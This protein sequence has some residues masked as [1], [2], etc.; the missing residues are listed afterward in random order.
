MSDI[1]DVWKTSNTILIHKGDNPDEIEN[2]RPISLSD[3]AYKLFMKCLARAL[4]NWCD[5][6]EVLSPAQK[7]FMP[8]DGVIEHNFLIN[9]HI[10]EARRNQQD[11]LLAWTDI[12]NAFGSVPHEVILNALIAN[13]VDHEFVSLVSNIYSNSTTRVFAGDGLTDPISIKRGVKQ[14]CPLSGILFNLAID[15]VLRTVQEEKEEKAILA[16]ADDLVL[17]APSPEELQ[18]LLSL[19]NEA[20]NK[21]ALRV[22]PNK[23]ATMHLS[24]KAPTGT[25]ATPF[26]LNGREL[27]IL[28][29]GDHYKYLGK[30]VGFFLMKSFKTVNE[31]LSLLQKIATSQLAPWQKLDAIKTFF[32]PSLCFSMRTAQVGKTGW[33]KVDTAVAKEVKNIL[34]VPERA[35]NYYIQADRSAGGCGIPSAAADCDFYLVD[36]AFKLLTSRDDHVKLASLGQLIR[37]FKAR[38]K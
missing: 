34:S 5:I 35:T 38:L 13:G 36:T 37:T 16:F 10:E 4:S 33:R 26:Q 1:P 23:C 11:R 6:H 30:P 21:I 12:S 3:T 31:A 9:Q 7:G 18:D 24:G 15:Q 32:F 14:G 22:N 20:L 17:L 8:H 19:T 29:E 28:G 2:W 27:R 25:R